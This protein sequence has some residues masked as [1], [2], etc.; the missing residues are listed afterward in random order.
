MLRRKLFVVYL[1]FAAFGIF[2]Q[3]MA[4]ATVRL[5]KTEPVSG[6]KLQQTIEALEKQQGRKLTKDE[7][8]QV[9][10]QM[11]NQILIIQAAEADRNITVSQQDVKKAAMNLLSQ[12]LQ[13]MGA[14]PP[15]AVLTDENQYKQLIQQQGM[16][17]QQYEDSVRK[18][19]LAEKYITMSD[20]QAFQSIPNPTEEELE[21][22][23]QQH[24]SEF[25]VSDSVWFKQIFFDTHNLSPADA[26]EKKA[27]AEEVYNKLINS[28][29]TFDQLIQS[30]SDDDMS[31]ARGGLI[32]PLMKGD[33]VAQQLYG[34]DFIT[35]VFALDIGETSGVLKSNVGYHIVKV[36]EKRS[37]QLLTKDDPE[38]NAYLKQLIYAQKYQQKFDEVTQNVIKDLRSRATI[39]YF[40]EYR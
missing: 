12:Q 32:G 38:V 4:V 23:Y 27:K 18:Q 28:P 17:V 29:A 37:A 10:D 8:K 33:K 40:G 30:E 22:L 5:E 39:N 25:V 1:F 26:L 36:T 19:L 15:G 34:E 7:K 21:K 35:K 16:T 6:K 9:L 3:D 2:A 13:A 31:K 24:I 20:P 11:I 14:I